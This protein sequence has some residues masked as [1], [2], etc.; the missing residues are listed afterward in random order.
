MILLYLIDDVDA[1]AAFAV[2]EELD[3]VGDAAKE[4]FAVGDDAHAAF[5]LSDDVREP[6]KSFH[7]TVETFLVESSETFVDE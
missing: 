5:A 4:F 6:G 2:A 1:A 7:D 3:F